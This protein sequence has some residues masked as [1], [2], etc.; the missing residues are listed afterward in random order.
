LAQ[1]WA[2]PAL[3]RR[4]Q[5]PASRKSRLGNAPHWHSRPTADL[6]LGKLLGGVSYASDFSIDCRTNA[7]G[8]D[9]S[10]R[11][12]GSGSKQVHPKGMLQFTNMR[13]VMHAVR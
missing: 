1:S 3:T 12:G 9:C 4:P 11:F 6:L 13:R 5:N 10:W 2:M 8:S 7:D